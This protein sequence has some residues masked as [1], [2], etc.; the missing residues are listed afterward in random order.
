MYFGRLGKVLYYIPTTVL[1]D[2]SGDEIIDSEVKM[3]GNRS[4][5]C[6]AMTSDANGNIF[7]GILDKGCI[8]RYNFMNTTLEP[9]KVDIICDPEKLVWINSIFWNDGYLYIVT[10]E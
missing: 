9:I 10:N 7:S 8:N 1:H 6:D 4:G 5:Y 3:A 2:D